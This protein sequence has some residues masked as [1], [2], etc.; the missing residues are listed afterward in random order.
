[1]T[2]VA[3]RQPLDVEFLHT[4]RLLLDEMSLVRDGDGHVV[5]PNSVE[6]DPI[7][8]EEQRRLAWALVLVAFTQM[9]DRAGLERNS[10]H[11]DQRLLYDAIKG[12]RTAAIFYQWKLS[13]INPVSHRNAVR[14]VIDRA[15]YAGKV[16]GVPCRIWIEDGRICVDDSLLD[17]MQHLLHMLDPNLPDVAAKTS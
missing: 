8:F 2:L 11:I 7:R 4:A 3:D 17:L 9:I 1:M 15:N 16:Q 12:I 5:D 10:L 14:D 13:T 6:A